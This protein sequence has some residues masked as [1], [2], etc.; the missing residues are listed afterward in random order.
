MHIEQHKTVWHFVYIYIYIYSNIAALALPQCKSTKELYTLNIK[1]LHKQEQ[2]YTLNIKRLH[3]QELRDMN[4][5]THQ[6][7]T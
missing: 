1:R 4:P 7:I 2:L 3:K 5:P 6:T